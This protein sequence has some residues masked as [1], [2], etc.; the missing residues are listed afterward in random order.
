LRNVLELV[1]QDVPEGADIAAGLGI[2]RGTQDHILEVDPATEA[3]LVFLEDRREDV[4]ERLGALAQLHP[5]GLG[6]A[7]LQAVAA[8]LELT[9]EGSKQLGEVVDLLQFDN[10]VVDR[11]GRAGL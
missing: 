2:V 8:A 5:V 7:V 9:Q 1:D 4:Q 10:P 6:L 3:L 11:V